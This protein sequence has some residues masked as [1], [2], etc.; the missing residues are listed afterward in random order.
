[1][2]R[3]ISSRS[4]IN[5]FYVFIC[6]LMF[7]T[8]NDVLLAENMSNGAVNLADVVERVA[9]AVVSIST[10]KTVKQDSIFGMDLRGEFEFFFGPHSSQSKQ[11]KVV[12]RASGVVISKDGIIVTNYH[13]I[14]EA[15]EINI[16]F[17]D[18]RVAIAKLVEYDAKTDLAVV[19]VDVAYDLQPIKLGDSN[20]IRVGDTVLAVGAPFGLDNT[21]THGI[22]SG[23]SR[24]ISGSPVD[25]IQT[26][27]S[28]NVGNSGGP[29]INMNGEVI[30]INS[31]ILSPNGANVGIGLSIP[32]N[33]AQTIV[34]TLRQGK[35]VVY[36]WLGVYVQAIPDSLSESLNAVKKRGVLVADVIAGSPAEKSGIKDGDIIVSFNDMEISNV[37]MLP[38]I[39]SFIPVGTKV[40]LIL[41][42]GNKEIVHELKIEKRPEDLPSATSVDFHGKDT[43]SIVFSGVK[44]IFHEG[45]IF[46]D[47]VGSDCP[48]CNGSQYLSQGDKIVGYFSKETGSA[49]FF[50]INSLKD[51]K[52]AINNAKVFHE[53]RCITVRVIKNNSDSKSR[54]IIL[55][56]YFDICEPVAKKG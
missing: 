21:V 53:K 18:D 35:K 25:L 10:T 12:T 56:Q 8:S 28:I 51:F 26:D 16:T 36:G 45:V 40:K 39:V 44:F 43:D 4:F 17:F 33:I 54:N 47:S 14:K 23:R 29:L 24:Y 6:C 7:T 48:S 9:P 31:A 37:H 1:M 34:A 19:K 22:V 3:V 30:G 46:V 38:G 49:S 13:V 11:R 50:K 5:M 41:L 15:D 20:K 27:A 2:Q 52:S 55:K 42:R 32:S